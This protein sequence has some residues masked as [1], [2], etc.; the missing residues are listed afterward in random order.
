MTRT[1]SLGI[2]CFLFC[3]STNAFSEESRRSSIAPT[4]GPENKAMKIITEQIAKNNGDVQLKNL[5][6][7]DDIALQDVNG[8]K[9]FS[10]ENVIFEGDFVVLDDYPNVT[11]K[12]TT[13]TFKRT[14]SIPYVTVKDVEIHHCRFEE[15]IN[16]DSLTTGGFTLRFSVL[17]EESWLRGM[18][19]KSF[20]LARSTFYKTLDLTGSQFDQF[21]INS[22][23]PLQAKEPIRISWSQFGDQWMKESVGSALLFDDKDT[24]LRNISV[25]LQQWRDNFIK[26]GYQRDASEVNYQ[27][28]E[29][30]RRYLM[31]DPADRW[32]AYILGLPN[33]YGTRPYRPIMIGVVV[34]LVFAVFYWITDPFVPQEDEPKRPRRPLPVFSLLYSIDTFIPVVAVTRV[35]EWGWE[36]SPP[37]RFVEVSERLLGLILSGLA[38]YSISYHVL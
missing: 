5:T 30:N 38:A 12:F 27:I 6:L 29:L 33:R 13:C 11:F 8:L 2:C 31:R 24:K 21:Y 20:F 35:R 32:A 9:N 22:L 18:R 34:I 37:Y 26:I 16:F 4:L 3:L 19:T 23:N 15:E 28:I 14:L 1:V 7:G 36:V 17:R 10:C 25:L